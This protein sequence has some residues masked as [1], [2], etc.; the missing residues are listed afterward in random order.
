MTAVVGALS[1][2]QGGQLCQDLKSTAKQ[3][4]SLTR[5]WLEE[6]APLCKLE[7]GIPPSGHRPLDAQP[8][9]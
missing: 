7:K 5:P 2:V 8:G 9:K 3:V 1:W 4:S 6:T